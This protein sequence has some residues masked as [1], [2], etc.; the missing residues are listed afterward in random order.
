MLPFVR[1]LRAVTATH[2]Y[3]HRFDSGLVSYERYRTWLAVLYPRSLGRHPPNAAMLPIVVR[4]CVRWGSYTAEPG[5]AGAPQ[6]ITTAS[7]TPGGSGPVDGYGWVV[8][9]DCL[10]PLFPSLP[11]ERDFE[12]GGRCIHHTYGVLPTVSPAYH[13][14]TA[15][16]L[17]PR[18]RLNS[19]LPAAG[20]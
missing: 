13:R 18:R 11:P 8:A 19:T 15:S 3:H 14:F 9:A 7:A 6:C 2:L 16:G 5:R 20:T 1:P 17:I 12:R 10:H 4:C